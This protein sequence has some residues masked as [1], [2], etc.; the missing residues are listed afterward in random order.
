[1]PKPRQ[2]LKPLTLMQ[3]QLGKKRLFAK[4]ESQGII[5]DKHY[6]WKNPVFKKKPEFAEIARKRADAEVAY[7]GRNRFIKRGQ[8]KA[9][10]RKTEDDSRKSGR[11]NA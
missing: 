1:M 9:I 8:T 10:L 4:S 3:M 11:K 2:Q 6:D 5:I 7:F